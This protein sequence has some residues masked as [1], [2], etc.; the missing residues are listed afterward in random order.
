[1]MYEWDK[2]N[3][4]FGSSIKGSA[5]QMSEASKAIIIYSPI[6]HSK[7]KKIHYKKP[8]YLSLGA[9][10]EN[11]ALKCSDL[12]FG[13]S[14]LCDTLYIEDEINNYLN[15]SDFEQI[16]TLIFGHPEEIPERKERFS[17]DKLIIN[18]F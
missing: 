11:M 16:S 9:A 7:N 2:N 15:L 12:G 10:I 3:K 1:M 6:Y 18:K 5:T 13:S 17:M 4:N 14:W 8:D